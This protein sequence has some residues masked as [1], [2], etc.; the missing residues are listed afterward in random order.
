MILYNSKTKKAPDA[1]G[2]KVSIKFDVG[3][4]PRSQNWKDNFLSPWCIDTAVG[5]VT[6]VHPPRILLYV[7]FVNYT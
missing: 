2:D 4:R 3:G 5:N 1:E 7:L 6:S